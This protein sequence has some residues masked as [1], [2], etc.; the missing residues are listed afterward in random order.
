[1]P[2][3]KI[4]KVTACEGKVPHPD[5]ASAW[6]AVRHG[7]LVLRERLRPYHCPHCKSWHTGKPGR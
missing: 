4:V 1:M 3:T 6:A 7:W 5:R 2:R